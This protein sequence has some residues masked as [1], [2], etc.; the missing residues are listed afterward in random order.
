[1]PTYL[2]YKYIFSSFRIKVVS[3][4]FFQL[5]LIRIKGKNVGSSSLRKRPEILQI[6]I[7]TTGFLFYKLESSS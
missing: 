1:M 2:K 4:F 6:M 5:N 3:G 7:Q